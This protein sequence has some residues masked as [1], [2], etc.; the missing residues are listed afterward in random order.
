[1]LSPRGSVRHVAPQM[2]HGPPHH[3][4][5]FC[6]CCPQSCA[7]VRTPDDSSNVLTLA[8]ACLQK[9]TLSHT[10]DIVIL[11]HVGFIVS[12]IF[13]CFLFSIFIFLVIFVLGFSFFTLLKMF[14]LLFAR[15]RSP[16]FGTWEVGGETVL[17]SFHS[18]KNIF[19]WKIARLTSHMMTTEQDNDTSTRNHSKHELAL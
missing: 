6:F 13:H 5:R 16:F 10:R 11:F 19:C 8:Q 3:L 17:V 9:S 14:G 1:M 15:F 2:V 18:L 12:F 4:H 7:H